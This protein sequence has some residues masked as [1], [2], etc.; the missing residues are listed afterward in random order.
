MP[1]TYRHVISQGNPMTIKLF[2]TDYPLAVSTNFINMVQQQINCHE[3][4]NTINHITVKFTDPKYDEKPGGFHPTDIQLEK[5]FDGTWRIVSIC[6]YCN[7]SHTRYPHF[8]KDLEFDF[9][10][11]LYHNIGSVFSDEKAKENFELW[12]TN[13]LYFVEECGVYG[14]EIQMSFKPTVDNH[15][16]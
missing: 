9:S 12:Q 5:H 15:P 8:A 10:N 4:P 16:T 3:V 1:V 2:T 14:T 6:D 13:F 7:V 11:K